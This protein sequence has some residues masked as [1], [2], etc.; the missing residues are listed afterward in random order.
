M[1]RN[2]WLFFVKDLSELISIIERVF[3]EAERRASGLLTIRSVAM[4]AAMPGR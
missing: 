1:L 3:Q 2:S 4:V